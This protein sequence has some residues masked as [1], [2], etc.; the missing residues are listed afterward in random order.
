MALAVNEQQVPIE[1]PRVGATTVSVERLRVNH[2]SQRSR[3][4]YVNKMARPQAV[5]GKLKTFPE[6]TLERRIRRSNA[7]RDD[8]I[9]RYV[10]AVKEALAKL[11]D[12]PA[13]VG[14]R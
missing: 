8:T 14:S 11:G 13:E 1:G 5:D 10:P 3:D 9:K 12:A 7:V 6:N 2:Y 4:E